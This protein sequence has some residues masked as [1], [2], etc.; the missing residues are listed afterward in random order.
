MNPALQAVTRRIVER[1]AASRGAYL[2]RVDRM[3]R[4]PPR[5]AMSLAIPSLNRVPVSERGLTIADF[6][7]PIRVAERVSPLLRNVGLVIAGALLI[8]LTAR[9]AIPRPGS[10]VPYTLQTFGIL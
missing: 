10:P 2:A 7:V 4:R 1:S 6:L 9:I 8:Y 5:E 3:L